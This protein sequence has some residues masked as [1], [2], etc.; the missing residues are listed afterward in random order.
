[1]STTEPSQNDS[2]LKEINQVCHLAEKSIRDVL[3]TA[4]NVTYL[5]ALHSP[6]TNRDV[7]ERATSSRSIKTK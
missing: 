2:L 3:N 1:M 5:L 4:D 6:R 7:D